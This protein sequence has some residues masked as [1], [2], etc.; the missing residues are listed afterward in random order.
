M[1]AREFREWETR[2]ARPPQN[3]DELY[4]VVADRLDD[5]EFDLVDHDF[6]YRD[7]LQRLTD[8]LEVQPHIARYFHDHSRGQYSVNHLLVVARGLKTK[9]GF[10]DL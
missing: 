3:P 8:E 7:Q 6:G 9:V 10:E 4:D 2:Y 5:M 1:T